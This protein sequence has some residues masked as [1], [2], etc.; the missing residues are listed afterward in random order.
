MRFDEPDRSLD[1]P[2]EPSAEAYRGG[3]YSSIDSVV[4]HLPLIPE[5]RAWLHKALSGIGRSRESIRKVVPILHELFKRS[6]DPMVPREVGQRF[7]AYVGNGLVKSFSGPSAQFPP[8][9]FSPIPNSKAGG[10]HKQVG[11]KY[12]YW[13]RGVGLTSQSQEQGAA[14]AGRGQQQ[15]PAGRQP[16]QQQQQ[17][18]GRPGAQQP[19]GGARPAG[20][21]QGGGA[22]QQQ[23]VEVEDPAE[24]QR[25][26]YGGN[27]QATFNSMDEMGKA[28]ATA[29]F[30]STKQEMDAVHPADPYQVLSHS[31]IPGQAAKQMREAVAQGVM[32]G[33]EAPMFIE[34]VN[35][36]VKHGKAAG[37]DPQ[38]LGELVRQNVQKMLHQDR[39]SAERLL[40]DHGIRHIQVNIKSAHA[41]L[42]ALKGGGQTVKPLDYLM[43]SQIMVDHDM[44][45]T[46]DAIHYGGPGGDKHHPAASRVLFEQ[47][48][49][50]KEVFGHANAAKMAQIIET[51]SG[52]SLDWERDPIGSATRMADNTHLF[53]D[54]LPE[55][56][57]DSKKGVE[58][59]AKIAL[60]K[61]Y[62]G[63]GP[64]GG[65]GDSAKLKAGVK[66][67]QQAMTDHIQSRTD[68]DP[69][70]RPILLSSV[71]EIGPVSDYFI[72]SR[73]A[74]RNPTFDFSD[75]KL[76]VNIDHS[77]VR[78]A[79]GEVFGPDHQ[80]K[81]FG[82]LLEDFKMEDAAKQLQQPPP[83][84]HIDLKDAG[85]VQ[86]TLR[87][88][89]PKVTGHGEG[90]KK[91]K[92]WAEVL[93]STH[94]EYQA[95]QGEKD[96]GKRQQRM[97]AWLGQLS[98]SRRPR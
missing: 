81:Q 43:A 68:I 76:N 30:A 35:G 94:A 52:S 92:E 62:V 20:G 57:V 32:S 6:R 97:D 16:G 59:L 11:G 1:K 55:V 48:P 95:I 33:H 5:D 34:V 7:A 54:K 2:E 23:P 89:A 98:K 91:E 49:G 86:A 38:T 88:G 10:Y 53:A 90:E 93:H 65:G 51:H 71:A 40:S 60:L 41:I 69:K 42:D 19:A 56:I 26:L 47:Q 39:K 9:G 85:K 22:S 63:A 21:A 31:D 87:W 17:P 37:V 14:P 80:D 13:Y 96:E 75:G 15:Q 8:P 18:G 28:K 44:G 78:E 24:R 58:L 83:S 36:F 45:Y 4:Q 72:A 25:A 50:L 61:R 66:T 84:V 79:I 46:T 70:Y 64:K 27:D 74:G 82:K 77:K 67:L 12:V 29:N 3:T 73:L